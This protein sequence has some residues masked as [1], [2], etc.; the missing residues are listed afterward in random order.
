MPDEKMKFNQSEIVQTVRFCNFLEFL[1]ENPL[2]DIHIKANLIS[3]L[4]ECR[5]LLGYMVLNQV[6]EKPK[7]SK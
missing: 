7:E 5:T 6:E 1:R 3:G 4:N 2:V